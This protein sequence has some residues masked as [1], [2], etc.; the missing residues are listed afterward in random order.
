MSPSQSLISI[1]NGKKNVFLTGQAGTGKTYLINEYIK[2]HP[3][4]IAA[5]ST[6]IAA[7]DIDGVTVHR[8]FSVPVPAY[9]ANPGD[10]PLSK[11]KVFEHTDTIIIDEISMCRAD[12]FSYAVRVLKR[13]EKL[14]HKK[15]RLIVTGDFSQL[16]PVIKKSDL[17]KLKYYGFDPSGYAFT[18]KEWQDLHFVTVHLDDI[19]RQEDLEFIHELGKAR[20]G[21]MS[22]VPYFNRFLTDTPPDDAVYLCGTNAAADAINQE[23]LNSLPG[24]TAAYFAEQEGRMPSEM[25]CDETL[26]LKPGARVIFTSNDMA[27]IDGN[28]HMGRFQ[29]GTQGVVTECLSDH[30]TVQ[31][32]SG[33]MIDVYPATWRFY[34]YKNNAEK[35][36]LEK[37]EIGSVSQIPLKIAK[38]ITIHKSQGK[39]FD[40]IV[41]SPQ[42]F[43]PGQLYVALSRVRGPEGLFLTGRISEGHL[44]LDPVVQKFYDDDFSYV[45]PES[46]LK[47]ILQIES[48]QNASSSSGKTS[49]R[50]APAKRK[51]AAAKK[52]K[53]R[54]KTQPKPVKTKKKPAEKQNDPPAKKPRAVIKK[55]IV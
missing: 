53:A 1:I 17:S 31:I 9:G 22:C 38:A 23:Y 45:I 19:K 14:F 18:T 32:G 46:R 2:N 3:S 27:R 44:K 42:I 10:V 28:D 30:V 51:H 25:P 49:S 29:N 55:K 39:T 4:T 15:I 6:G 7:V 12:V 40:K 11:L 34:S 5:A 52:Q 54:S 41:L 20:R 35:G 43:A 8:L 50:K 47:K 26:V 24:I 36:V 48:K 16:P 37:Q 13:A 21:D 33:R